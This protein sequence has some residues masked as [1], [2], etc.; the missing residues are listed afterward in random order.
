MRQWQHPWTPMSSAII[1]YHLNIGRVI[2]TP[3]NKKDVGSCR[4]PN[5]LLILL[6]FQMFSIYSRL[7]FRFLLGS[8]S[9]PK[10]VRRN[11]LVTKTYPETSSSQWK[12]PMVQKSDAPHCCPTP[13]SS[14]SQR[15]IH[16]L[17]AGFIQGTFSKKTQCWRACKRQTNLAS[18]K[19]AAGP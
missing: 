13:K 17:S 1:S 5:S 4:F 6:F 14:W 18:W 10:P 3:S 16:P 15:Q 19:T 11:C 2:S 12:Y 9:P 8:P 7:G